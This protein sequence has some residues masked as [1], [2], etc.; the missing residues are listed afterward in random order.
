MKKYALLCFAMG[1]ALTF[2]TSAMAAGD[3]P[4]TGIM[5]TPHDLRFPGTP[6]Y[7]ERVEQAGLEGICMYC[8]APHNARKLDSMVSYVPLWNHTIA[9]DTV[10][11]MYMKMDSTG[12]SGPGQQELTV[13]NL[14]FAP[15]S[16][17][18][19]CLSCHDGSVATNEYGFMLSLS[20]RGAGQHYITSP[21]LKNGFGTTFS[22]GHPIGF[23]YQSFVNVND[24]IN[25]VT[26]PVVGTLNGGPATIGELLWNGRVECIT[27][28]DVHNYKN[29]GPKFTWVNDTKSKLCRI[30]HGV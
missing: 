2:G 23:D 25:P 7:G 16:V 15:G 28:H 30:C 1:L 8:H 12:L 17:S 26:A 27:C 22:A 29:G 4:G 24:A 9:L 10:F 19:L 11:T 6:G 13:I 5:N 20:K 21:P 14:A 3:V 18:Q